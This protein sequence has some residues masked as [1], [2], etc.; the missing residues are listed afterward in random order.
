VSRAA[1]I[2]E[3]K[4]LG[5]N[6][7]R[8]SDLYSPLERLVL[9]YA[10]CLT[11]VPTDVPPELR[12]ALREHLTQAQLVELTTA[13]AWE[14][15]RARFNRAFDVQPQGYAGGLACPLPDRGTTATDS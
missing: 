9:E 1:D 12:D 11:R 7:W 4:I 13:V 8:E 3:A 2:D 5:V 6:R 15:Y 10:E 14:N